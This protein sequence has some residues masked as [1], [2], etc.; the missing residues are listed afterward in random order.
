M[1]LREWLIILGLALVTLIVVDGVRRLQRQRRVPR[2]D[3]VAE[4]TRGTDPDEQA[5]E[6]EINWELPNGGA[7]VVRPADYSQVQ[8][9]PKLERQEHPGPSRVLASFRRKAEAFRSDGEAPAAKREPGLGVG[10]GV[11][12]TPADAKAADAKAAD[13][14]AADAKAADAKAAD[15]KAAKVK[16]AKARKDEP[17]AGVAASVASVEPA[18]AAPVESAQAEPAKA[19]PV[20]AEPDQAETIKAEPVKAE[21][22]PQAAEPTRAEPPQAERREPGLSALDDDAVLAVDTDEPLAADPDDHDGHPQDDERYRLVDLEGMGDTLKSGSRRVGASVQRFGASLQK[23][24]AER[25]EQK[26]L[27]KAR[28]EKAKAEKAAL[29]A[30]RQR[31]AREQAEAEQAT[32]EAERRRLEAQAIAEADDN[33]PLFAPPRARRTEPA[34]VEYDYDPAQADDFREPE[35]DLAPALN[36]DKVRVHPV[37]EKALRHD[38]SAEHARETLSAA[39]ELIVI[40]VMSRDEEGFSGAALLDLMLACGLRYDRD[41][42]VFHRFE[43]EDP[44]SRLQ[45]SMV[46]VVKPGSFPIKAM[47]E[48]RTPG[49][50]L[51]MPLPGADDPSAAFEA[52]VE[53]AMVIVRHLG[54]ELK[55]ENHSVMTAQTV[56]FARQRVQEFVRRHRLHRYQVN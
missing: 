35:P 48:F 17:V 53:T 20:Q 1:E 38:V 3:E 4:E 15:A 30:E 37:L 13:A 29:E 55:D 33:D 42:G 51:L 32:R 18:A 47:D 34:D 45:F 9:K 28:R 21:P 7:R 19:E 52:M 40:S 24:L 44:E 50:T 12:D 2:L 25:R 39:S 11:A 27:E 8:P 49:I 6:A 16:V 56:G 31:L 54:G 14:K 23:T 10:E 36:S 41:M 5:R 46:N 22:V 43:T 26:R